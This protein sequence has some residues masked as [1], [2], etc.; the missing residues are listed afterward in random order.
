MRHGEHYYYYKGMYK[1]TKYYACSKSRTALK[2]KARLICG[3]DGFFHIKGI[4]PASPRD[5]QDEMRQLLELR[6][7]GDF[8]V[9]PGRVWRNVRDEMLRLYGESSGLR[10]ED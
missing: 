2:C 4:I 1:Q 3:E 7:L 9:V 5:V 10:Y 6:S 8:R